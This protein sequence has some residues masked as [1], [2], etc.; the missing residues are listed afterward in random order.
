MVSIFYRQKN[1]SANNWL[2]CADSSGVVRIYLVSKRKNFELI[3]CIRTNEGA[4]IFQDHFDEI[5]KEKS[6]FLIIAFANK[7]IILYRFFNKK[8]MDCNSAG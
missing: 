6:I 7:K 8:N 2:Y 1:E 3:Q 4:V 5:D